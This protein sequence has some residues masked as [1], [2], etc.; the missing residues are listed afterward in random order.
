MIVTNQTIKTHRL[1]PSVCELVK[2]YGVYA[3]NGLRQNIG[4]GYVLY[5]PLL[6]S[7]RP[8]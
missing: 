8:I 7:Q 4:E 1:T 3:I 2:F 6:L 5:S